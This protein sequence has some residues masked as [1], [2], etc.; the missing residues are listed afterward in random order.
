MPYLVFLSALCVKDLPAQLPKSPHSHVLAPAP[1]ASGAP[2]S[3]SLDFPKPETTRPKLRGENK[4]PAPAALPFIDLESRAAPERSQSDA[5]D[6]LVPHVVHHSGQLYSDHRDHRD[7]LLQ[8][9]PRPR[10]P[11][12]CRS[13]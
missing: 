7:L 9:D 13:H 8:C 6:Q 4:S 3:P 12:L 5:V 11:A 1:Y 2:T 10:H